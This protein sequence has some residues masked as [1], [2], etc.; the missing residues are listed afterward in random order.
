MHKI[1]ASPVSQ[2]RFEIIPT[3]GALPQD[4]RDHHQLTRAHGTH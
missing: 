3:N 1:L 4:M 2:K